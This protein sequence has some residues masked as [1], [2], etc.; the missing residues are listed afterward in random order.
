MS[1]I[2]ENQ[3]W[4]NA[5]S[6][7]YGDRW[8]K[9]NPYKEAWF[10]GYLKE[11]EAFKGLKILDVG[12]GVGLQAAT[13][14]A[15]GL[16]FSEGMLEKA[17]KRGVKT[18]K[19]KSSDLPFPDDCFDL[20]TS[21][22]LMEHLPEEERLPSILEF[23]RVVKKGGKVLIETNNALS[24]I[25]NTRPRDYT[26]FSEN[27][28]GDYG[29]D[30]KGETYQVYTHLFDKE[31]ICEL[32]DEAGLKLVS[33]RGLRFV[34][35]LTEFLKAEQVPVENVPLLDALIGR[36]TWLNPRIRYTAVK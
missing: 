32:I 25:Y 23:A 1:V 9:G 4:F 36:I 16:D 20:V 14:G 17:K 21:F 7:T 33:V 5:V 22:N 18:F 11:L 31:E 13:M 6:E 27:P 35:Y 28:Q 24:P 29:Y 30:S 12:C 15:W 8:Y 2:E 34:C 3:R 10:K 19:S 26:R